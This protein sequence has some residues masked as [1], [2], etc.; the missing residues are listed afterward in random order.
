MQ[1]PDVSGV[2]VNMLFSFDG[3]YFEVLSRFIDTEPVGDWRGMLAGLMF[4]FAEQGV[5]AS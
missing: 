4:V 1:F 3:S 2:E 5:S